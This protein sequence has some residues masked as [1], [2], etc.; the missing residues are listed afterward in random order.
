MAEKSDLSNKIYNTWEMLK[1]QGSYKSDSDFAVY[2]ISLEMRRQER[3]L[4]IK[5]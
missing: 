1:Y 5:L 2:L 4:N 3:L